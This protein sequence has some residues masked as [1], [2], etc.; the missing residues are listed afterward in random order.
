MFVKEFFA[1]DNSDK[2][3]KRIEFSFFVV[4][5]VALHALSFGFCSFPFMKPIETVFL[6]FQNK[7]VNFFRRKK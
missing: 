4:V 2:Q 6:V 7:F 5:V 1:L 3:Y